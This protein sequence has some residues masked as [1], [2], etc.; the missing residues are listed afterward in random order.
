MTKLF[1]IIICLFVFAHFGFSQSKFE[2][3]A[4]VGL[5]EALSVKAKY[6]DTL[7]IGIYQGF[8]FGNRWMTGVEGYYYFTDKSKY[9]DTRTFYMMSGISSTVFAQGYKQFEKIIFYY[10]FGK[11]IHFTPKVGID[12]DVG[13]ALVMTD[14]FNGY[15]VIP[16]PTFGVHLFF[17]I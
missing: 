13:L 3:D 12:A 4:G 10:R 7:K 15:A 17:R 14:D 11:S 5:F 6:G 16:F 1:G 9:E 2:V 8:A